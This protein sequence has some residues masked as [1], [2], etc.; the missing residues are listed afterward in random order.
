MDEV[1]SQVEDGYNHAAN[2]Y[3]Q[4]TRGSSSREFVDLSESS[5]LKD[6]K[7]KIA[8]VV[9]LLFILIFA[10]FYLN[11]DNSMGIN[12]QKGENVVWIN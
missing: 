9:I 5:F 2:E 11:K 4:S 7:G 8:A 1:S 12:E 10:Y 3:F 6:N